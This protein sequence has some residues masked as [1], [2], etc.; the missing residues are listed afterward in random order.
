METTAMTWIAPFKMRVVIAVTCFA[1]DPPVVRTLFEGDVP[2]G[3]R[4][5]EVG[6]PEGWTNLDGRTYCERHRVTVDERAE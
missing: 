6:I 5:P 2:R 3:D 1:C 4:V